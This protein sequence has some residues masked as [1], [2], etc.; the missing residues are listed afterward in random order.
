MNPE[1]VRAFYD[2]LEK[3]AKKEE[4]G[5]TSIGAFGANYLGAALG[6]L[7][8]G[9]AATPL[10]KEIGTDQKI[11][12]EMKKKILENLKMDPETVHH[13]HTG[14]PEMSHYYTRR[15]ARPGHPSEATLS[16][17]VRH[18]VVSPTDRA[19][20]ILAHELGHASTRP[21]NRAVK[22]WIAGRVGGPLLGT[23]ASSYMVAQDPDSDAAKWA[24]AAM[25]A[26]FA[27][28]LVD[29]GIA[30]YRGLRALRAAG[31]KGE[32]FRKAMMSLGKGFGSYAAGA[33]GAAS[34]PYIIRKIRQRPD[35]EDGG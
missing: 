20:E 22:A 24:P 34:V 10:V 8:G 6:S 2:E 15:V 25:G 18:M 19:P 16:P 30:S 32:Q 23:F 26:G 9:L 27:P 7:V 12:P 17:K 3:I 5:G 14:S 21:T 28:T 1:T 33:A 29:E 31:L 11:T 13:R 4:Q 35:D